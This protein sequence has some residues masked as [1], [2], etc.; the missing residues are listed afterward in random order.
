[1]NELAG[2]V[3]FLTLSTLLLPPTS[4][5]A[6]DWSRFRGPNG[7]GVVESEN[8]PVEFGPE[9]NVRWKTELAFGRS[10]PVLTRDSVFLT[11]STE[12]GLS[13]I[14]LDSTTGEPRW[15]RSLERAR[16]A[17]RYKGTDSAVASPVTDGENVYA[18]FQELGLV[19]YDG[20][21]KRRWVH[22]VG[23]FNSF[24]GVASSPILAGDMLL[25]AC[26]AQS[27]AF[28]L[29]VNKDDG[30]ERWRADRSDRADSWTTPL[31]HPSAEEPGEVI[32]FGDR[33]L[34]GYAVKT[35][36]EVWCSRKVGAGPVSSPV[37]HEQLLF[38]CTPFHAEQPMP[39]FDTILLGLDRDGD[40]KLS[41]V[42]VAETE[43][44][45]HFGWL[46]VAKDGF[47]DREEWDAVIAVSRDQNY[48]LVAFDLEE[49]REDESSGELWRY[50]RNL[51]QI[52]TPLFYG[53]VLY[54]VAD[55]GIVTTLDPVTGDV[56]QRTRI[57]D[58]LGDC[59]PSPVAG[60]GKVYVTSN[61]GRIAVLEAGPLWKV[62][63]I[64]DLAEEINATPAIGD[65][66][67]LYVRT[68]SALYCFGA[69]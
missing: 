15:E 28:L 29:A 2:S 21:G 56:H 66:G 47:V 42:E 26:D 25:L 1:M 67:A 13:V 20:E 23:P 34:R 59:F 39:P 5:R 44:A 18:F 43:M 63:A 14:C 32:L 57:G 54:L 46:D 9:Q 36:E 69:E 53:D 30:Q 60:D 64:N 68:W 8:L 6:G 17:K 38:A 62:L 55:G 16:V 65:E 48:G 58:G 27:G 49:L 4:P 33:N 24:Y 31:L 41:A 37:L 22:P 3:A 11:A 19:S 52:A 10:S 40:G 35:G 50:K 45:D 61:D 12:R 51:P 7:S